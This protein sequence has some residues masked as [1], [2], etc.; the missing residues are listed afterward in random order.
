MQINQSAYQPNMILTTILPGTPVD[1][2]HLFFG[3]FFNSTADHRWPAY[4][5]CPCSV[6]YLNRTVSLERL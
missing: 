1:A 4:T 5:G 2:D 3:S 6:A